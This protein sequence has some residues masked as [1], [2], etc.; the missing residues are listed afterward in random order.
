MLVICY[1]III[2]P[3]RTFHIPYTIVCK[4]FIPLLLYLEMV[5][6]ILSYTSHH[7]KLQAYNTGK[8]QVGQT[9]VP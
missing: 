1:L 8:T 3:L 9:R 2:K 5:A 6:G 7:P 4:H